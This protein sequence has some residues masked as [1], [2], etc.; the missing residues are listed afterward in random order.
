MNSEFPES[1]E[2]KKTNFALCSEDSYL[3]S[4][5][6]KLAGELSDKHKEKVKVL[7]EKAPDKEKMD[8]L[9]QLKSTEY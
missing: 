5:N 1:K 9:N 8:E 6:K 4:Y 3:K 7:I 2:Y